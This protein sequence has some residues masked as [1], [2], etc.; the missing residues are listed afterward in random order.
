MPQSR[1]KDADSKILT[2]KFV[3]TT[4]FT[5]ISADEAT[6]VSY[7]YAFTLANYG[8]IFLLVL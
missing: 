6:D 8:G 2:K 3:K 1:F 5:N 7:S 4:D